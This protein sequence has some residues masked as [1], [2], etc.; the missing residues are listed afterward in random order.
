MNPEETAK[1]IKKF[2]QDFPK[3]PFGRAHKGGPSGPP[4][5][6]EKNRA[7]LAEYEEG[8]RNG[9]RNV[10]DGFNQAANFISG[11]KLRRLWMLTHK[12]WDEYC[13]QSLG[14]SVRTAQRILRSWQIKLELESQESGATKQRDRIVALTP[15]LNRSALEALSGVAKADL[16]TVVETAAS[17]GRL[18][19][20]T[21]KEAARTHKRTK[22]P[23]EKKSGKGKSTRAPAKPKPVAPEAPSYVRE[24]IEVGNDCRKLVAQVYQIIG[25]LKAALVDKPA[26]ALLPKGQPLDK[27]A[28]L[29][30]GVEWR[31][32]FGVCPRCKGVGCP[33][34][35]GHG[36]AQRS[37]CEN[38]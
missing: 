21:I 15:Q 28:E 29:F 18:T 6:N 10:F 26:G 19:E 16:L 1:S 37:S 9:L 17:T 11:L 2:V 34:C 27:A 30:K 14:I 23:A 7:A 20:T 4:E 35:D 32:P 38:E 12:T 33:R 5:D 3:G 8:V 31:L 36:W 25:R 22:P 13:E 24:A